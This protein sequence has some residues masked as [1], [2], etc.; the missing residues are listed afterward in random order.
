MLEY[1][2]RWGKGNKEERKER[3]QSKRF[4][5]VRDVSMF[6]HVF[7]DGFLQKIP[8][9][10][11]RPVFFCVWLIFFFESSEFW[12]RH[13]RCQNNRM[14][15]QSTNKRYFGRKTTAFYHLRVL[16]VFK[17]SRD[18]KHRSFPQRLWCVIM[19]LMSSKQL[20]SR[21]P[22][23][24][25]CRDQIK[26]V[27]LDILL[28]REGT[29]FSITAAHPMQEHGE[30]NIHYELWLRLRCETMW[31]PTATFRDWPSVFL[32]WSGKSNSKE[33]SVLVFPMRGG[34]HQKKTFYRYFWDVLLQCL[35][36]S[37]RIFWKKQQAFVCHRCL[38]FVL[39]PCRAAFVVVGKRKD[40]FVFFL[41]A[42]NLQNEKFYGFVNSMNSK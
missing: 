37:E 30:C 21:Q 2:N 27:H 35:S 38:T 32:L 28:R 15:F 11:R 29:N 26:Y 20:E 36:V 19:C 34:K 1:N 13:L 25:S 9:C 4:F 33:T 23:H 18:C 39:S 3:E 41:L 17:T 24:S 40:M 12:R 5:A 31:S 10:R 42:T 22:R 6:Q 8:E 7:E 14:R 16:V